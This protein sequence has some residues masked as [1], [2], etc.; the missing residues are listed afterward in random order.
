[1]R[2]LSSA[3]VLGIGVWM[4]AGSPARAQLGGMGEDVKKGAGDAAREQVMKGAAEKAGLPTPAAPGAGGAAATAPAGEP[5][6]VPPAA[7]DAPAAAPDSE[8]GAASAPAAEPKVEPGVADAP[9]SAP[10]AG[11]S[12]HDAGGVGKTMPKLP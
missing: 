8:T 3:I 4:L 12:G 7:A 2:T 1:M 9:T 5:P 11:E 6:V 10:G